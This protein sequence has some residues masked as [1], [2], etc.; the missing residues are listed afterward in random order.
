MEKA[1]VFV[2]YPEGMED[3]GNTLALVLQQSTEIALDVTQLHCDPCGQQF[4]LATAG[5][6][7][8]R[9]DLVF[10][11]IFSEKFESAQDLIRSFVGTPLIPLIIPPNL[12]E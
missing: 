2:T 6:D 9:P 3:A 7:G 4:Q 1:K 12:P 5:F 10:L 8:S 11:G